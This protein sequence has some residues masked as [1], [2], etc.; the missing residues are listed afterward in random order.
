MKNILGHI[1]RN[2][3]EIIAILE[4][5]GSYCCPTLPHYR[6]NT[7]KSVCSNLLKHGLVKKSGNTSEGVNLIPSDRFRE[8]QED[9]AQGLTSLG[10]IKWVKQKFPPKII[11]KS[12]VVC[13]V[14]FETLNRQQKTCG[15]QCRSVMKL[16]K[17]ATRQATV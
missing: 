10:P 11:S 12:C 7:V 4:S 17:T 5:G 6:Y 13:G 2:Q 9:K 16:E 1:S 8:W 15:K 3:D 14:G